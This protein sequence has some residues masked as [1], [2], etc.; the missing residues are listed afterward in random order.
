M[1]TEIGLGNIVDDCPAFIN[2]TRNF[3]L[4][5]HALSLPRDRVVLE[6][7]EDLQAD[8]EITNA[9]QDLSSQGYTI[10][11]NDFVYSPHMEPLIEIADI[12][13]V[14]LPAID[15]SD[16][17]RIVKLRRRSKARLLAEKIETHEEFEFCRELGFDLYR[18]YFLSKP[19]IVSGTST[20]TSRLTAVQLVGQL[21]DPAVDVDNLGQDDEN[22]SFAVLQTDE[23]HQFSCWWTYTTR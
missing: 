13:K 23:V 4:K 10:A 19:R 5:G 16:L 17:P 8:P 1:F 20:S 3:N 11:L 12:I 9:F 15:N 7:L 22:R 6:V 14:E 2:I 21:S 18:G